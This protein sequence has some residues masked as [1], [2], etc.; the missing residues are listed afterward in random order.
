M[1]GVG[2]TPGDARASATR[3]FTRSV[4]S[5]AGAMPKKRLT[6][7]N[8][9]GVPATGI[10]NGEWSRSRRIPSRA[11]VSPGTGGTCT[12]NLESRR[13][14]CT[15]GGELRAHRGRHLSLIRWWSPSPTGPRPVRPPRVTSRAPR[16]RRRRTHHLRRHLLR[17]RLGGGHGL[18]RPRLHHHQLRRPRRD[19]GFGLGRSAPRSPSKAASYP[20]SGGTCGTSVNPA[21]SCTVVIT[22]APG[23]D[24]QLLDQR[25]AST[26]TTGRKRNRPRA[27]CRARARPPRPS[28]SATDRRT[29]LVRSR[30][31]PRVITRSR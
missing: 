24:R 15:V 30:R 9:G 2:A 18:V 10:V 23:S 28:P 17:L 31:T 5:R 25:C 4:R 12:A 22:F 3:P 6:L 29:A 26:I 7:T 19:D 1:T 14:T 21:G 13:V 20:G 16:W 11:A 8:S 27:R